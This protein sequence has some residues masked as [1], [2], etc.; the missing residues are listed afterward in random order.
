MNINDYIS[1]LKVVIHSF[2]IVSSYNL[3]IDRKTEDAAYISGKIDFTDGS[4]VDF[5]EFIEKN[6]AGIEKYK[7]GYN[8]R[9]GDEVLFRY[10]N[11]HDPGA[12]KLA[13]FPHHKHLGKDIIIESEP[14]NLWDVME[15]IEKTISEQR[16]SEII[17]M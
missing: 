8:Y 4:A 6:D 2:A 10:D 17:G 14:V 9:K 15:E 11:A 13:S 16:I 7:Y 12:K 3:N 1:K 5:K